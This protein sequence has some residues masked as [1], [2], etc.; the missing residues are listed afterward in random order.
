MRNLRNKVWKHDQATVLN[1]FKPL[2]HAH[3]LTAAH[4]ILGQ[5]YKNWGPKYPRVIKQL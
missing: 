5:F 1:D 3:D 2:N 4:E